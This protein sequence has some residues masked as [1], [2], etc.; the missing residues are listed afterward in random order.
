MRTDDDVFVRGERLLNLLSGMNRTELHFVGQAGR[1]RSSEE[2]KL[3][4]DWNE[5]FCMGGTGMLMTRPVLRRLAPKAG[6]LYYTIYTGGRYLINR[7]LSVFFDPAGPVPA[8]LQGK[9]S[10]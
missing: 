7:I 9:G 10:I 1:G 2:G 4:L 8:G 5:N 6:G 3:A